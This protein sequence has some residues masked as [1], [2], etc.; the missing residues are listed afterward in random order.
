MVIMTAGGR[1]HHDAHACMSIMTWPPAG[2]GLL[3][4]ARITYKI[5]CTRLLC[6]LALC[7]CN[8]SQ[9][10]MRVPFRSWG[11][12]QEL[13]YALWRRLRGDS[14]LSPWS[15]SAKL[16]PRAYIKMHCHYCTLLHDPPR[17][18]SKAHSTPRTARHIIGLAR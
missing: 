9:R 17:P 10:G 13:C 8:L 1:L 4:K 6:R 12:R 15:V 16:S 3:L 11:S 14:V 5:D 2:G 18:P 7:P